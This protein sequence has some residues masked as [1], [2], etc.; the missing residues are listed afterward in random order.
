MSIELKEIREFCSKDIIA[1]KLVRC[2]ENSLIRFF[3]RDSI[4]LENDVHEQTI[5][6][7]LGCYLER[8]IRSYN[9]FDDLSVDCEYNRDVDS[10]SRRKEIGDLKVEIRDYISLYLGKF[11]N[12]TEVLESIDNLNM[13]TFSIY[14]IEE[15]LENKI[16]DKLFRK[17][18]SKIRRFVRPDIIVHRRGS[19]NQNLLVIEAK[20]T[21]DVGANNNDEIADIMKLR[22]YVSRS[23]GNSLKYR[24]GVFI[25]LETGKSSSGYKVIWIE[26]GKNEV[27]SVGTYISDNFNLKMFDVKDGLCFSFSKESQNFQVDCGSQ[28]LDSKIPFLKMYNSIANNY[29]NNYFLFSHFHRDHYSGLFSE[30]A[31][32]GNYRLPID[33]VYYPGI[34]E[35]KGISKGE[36]ENLKLSLFA[37][38]A[39]FAHSKTGLINLDFIELIRNISEKP[40]HIQP[41]YKGDVIQA[42]NMDQIEVLWP[43]KFLQD[44]SVLKSIK[45]ALYS[46]KEALDESQLLREIYESL[47]DG[48][49]IDDIEQEISPADKKPYKHF[50]G[51]SKPKI[52]EKIKQADHDLKDTANRLSLAFH[53]VSRESVK[54]LLFLGDL[55][56]GETNKVIKDLP[57]D[58]YY[59]IFIAPHHGTYYSSELRSMLKQDMKF[60]EFVL[61]SFGNRLRWNTRCREYKRISNR[62]I[63]TYCWGDFEIIDIPGSMYVRKLRTPDIWL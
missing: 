27:V 35:I 11:E 26:D 4:L 41:L 52:S 28:N 1:L 7:K 48:T 56:N 21:N 46:F 37:M 51:V 19:N 40:F 38:G 33:N 2:L 29:N 47:K 50:D 8:E 22:K 44:E 16:P 42:G 53:V 6:H 39:Y 3:E 45:K 13:K 24:Y 54:K 43:P 32:S 30:E 15:I 55:K 5:T 18:M 62:C 10:F 25:S 34:P 63:S 61:L 23:R 17:I 14:D 9:F 60:S 58:R 12:K 36:R 31:R 49:Y 57:F 59:S 20:K